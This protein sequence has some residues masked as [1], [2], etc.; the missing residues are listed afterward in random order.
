LLRRAACLIAI[1]GIPIVGMV[2]STHL[3]THRWINDLSSADRGRR[4]HALQKLASERERAAVPAI[5]K[6]LDGEEDRELL[7][8]AGYAALRVGDLD[9]V[10][11]LRKRSQT[12][13]DDYT[14][15]KL[16]VYACRLSGRDWRLLDW[17]LAGAHSEQPWQRVGC[18]VGLLEL[19]RPE[20][21]ELLLAQIKGASPDVQAFAYTEF[22]RL[23]EPMTQAVGHMVDWP[24]K[25]SV[26]PAA[27]DR[28][29]AAWKQCAT[30][31]L[32]ADVLERIEGGD[33]RW[34]EVNRLLHAR[35]RVARFLS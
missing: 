19:G 28:L 24:E 23:A 29:A 27:W 14:R 1:C 18:C 32:L 12:G 15:A 6:S 33:V 11:T 16:I 26:T 3:Q 10:A 9:S 8:A 30:P 2:I 31:E 20:G 13:P 4:L 35:K 7:E 21:G 5:R 25:D 34:H 17:V 22:R